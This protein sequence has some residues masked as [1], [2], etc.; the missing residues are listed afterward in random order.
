MTSDSSGNNAGSIAET[1]PLAI[2]RLVASPDADT[3][4]Y[5]PGLFRIRL[6]MSSDVLPYFTETLQPVSS[7]NGLTQPFSV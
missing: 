4:S 3:P 1:L 5:C 6:T 7:S 2:S